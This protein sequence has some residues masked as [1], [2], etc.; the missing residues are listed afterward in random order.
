MQIVAARHLYQEIKG[1]RYLTAEAWELIGAFN[2]VHAIANSVDPVYLEGKLIGY[3]A[4]VELSR[5]GETVGA[6]E[7]VCGMEEYPCQGR[8]GTAKDR[9]AMSAAQTWATSKA[10]RLN[11]SWVAV[12]AGFE[13][14]PAEE[15]HQGA[16]HPER[17][18]QP[19]TPSYYKGGAASDVQHYCTAHQ[20]RWFKT[21]KM[22]AYAHPPV[23]GEVEW[24]YEPPEAGHV[25]SGRR[26]TLQNQEANADGKY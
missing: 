19:D 2:N 24:C 17:N 26:D 21:D 23:E 4:R 7:M 15:M 13:P 14:T 10:Y 22:R 8:S 25:S 11:Y 18:T 1:K 20:K 5:H 3:K 12:L 16:V 6:A 9:A